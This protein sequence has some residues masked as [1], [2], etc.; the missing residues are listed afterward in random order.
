MERVSLI[1]ASLASVFCTTSFGQV[2]NSRCVTPTPVETRV[3]SPQPEGVPVPAQPVVS[4]PAATETPAPRNETPRARIGKTWFAQVGLSL[5]KFRTGPYEDVTMYEVEMHRKAGPEVLVG[6]RRPLHVFNLSGLDYGLLFGLSTRGTRMHVDGE[7]VSEE[8]MLGPFCELSLSYGLELGLPVKLSP[9]LGLFTK[10]D[11]FTKVTLDGDFEVNE[12][13]AGERYMAAE[14][15]DYVTVG[16]KLE[17]ETIAEASYYNPLDIG[18]GLGV[19]ATYDR[20][21]FDFTFRQG[22]TNV[23]A[24]WDGYKSNQFVLSVGYEF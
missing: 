24:G 11:V 4:Q 21:F 1:I 12:Y 23:V 20:Y 22:F 19:R 17:V 3:V 2:V 16:K 5:S 10:A 6:F 15:L 18:L 13:K 8:R 7:Q 9:H 14:V